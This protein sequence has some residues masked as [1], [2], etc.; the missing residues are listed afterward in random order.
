MTPNEF[1]AWFDGFTEAMGGLPNETQWAKIK[2]RVAE[3]DGKAISYPVYVDR[4]WPRTWPRYDDSWRLYYGATGAFPLSGGVSYSG[5]SEPR[6]TLQCRAVSNGGVGSI[7][8]DS[9][10]AL[11]AV[12]KADFEGMAS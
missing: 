5:N 9:M 11:Y 2:A 8:F 7:E 6:T 3:I 12:G 1:K 4:Y 10:A